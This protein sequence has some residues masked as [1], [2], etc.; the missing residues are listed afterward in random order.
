LS[1]NFSI[2]SDG[3]ASYFIP[4]EAPP[5]TAKMQPNIQS[6]TTAAAGNGLLG[7]GWQLLGLWSITRVKATMAQDN[8]HGTINCDENDRFALDGVRLTLISGSS[9]QSAEAVYHAERESWR[10]VVPTPIRPQTRRES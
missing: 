6:A 4:I 5:G 7:M 8:Y 3:G 2:E 1:D 10:K 9:Y